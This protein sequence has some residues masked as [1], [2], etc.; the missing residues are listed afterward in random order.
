MNGASSTRIVGTTMRFHAQRLVRGLVVVLVAAVSSFVAIP[1]RA[2][3]QSDE[4]RFVELINQVRVANGVGPLQYNAELSNV[5]RRWA[6]KMKIASVGAAS[7]NCLISHNPNL[8]ND[9]TLKWRKLGENVGCGDVGVEGLHTAFVNSPN[10]FHNIVDAQFDTI[11]IGIVYVDN[12]MF[13]TEQF[14]DADDAPAPNPPNELALSAAPARLAVAG[15]VTVKTPPKGKTA[16]AKTG[17][18]SPAR[19]SM[20]SSV[21]RSKPSR[22]APSL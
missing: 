20:A 8:R 1:A 2:D 5:A 6:E 3:V 21:T 15:A 4:Q 17:K 11:G 9:V 19:R 22:P 13:I 12:M 18:K 16:K 7:D 14:M 10:H